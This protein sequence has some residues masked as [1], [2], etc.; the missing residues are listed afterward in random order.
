[1]H[2]PASDHPLASLPMDVLDRRF[3]IR[4]AGSTVGREVQAGVL[5]FATLSYILFVQ[6]AVLGG[7]GMDPGG[8]LF[9]TCVA[10]AIACLWMG[11]FANHPFALAPAMGHNFFFAFVVC[12]AM[13]FSWQ[14][15]LAANLMAG[16]VFLLLAPTRFRESVMQAVPAPVR[17]GIAAGIGLLV[18]MIGLQWSGLVVDSPATLVQLGD[19]ADPVAGL[20]LFGLGLGAVL[21]AARVPGA[22]LLS[23]VGTA[24][25]GVAAHELFGVDTALVQLDGVISAPP[26]PS[27]TAF[28]LDF[29]GLFARPIGDWLTVFAVLFLLD[30]FDTVGSLVGLGRRAGSL[31]DDG[32]LP[33]AS[34]AFTADAAGT[35][36]G[37]CLGTSTVTSY[38][39]SAAGI[40]AGGRTGLT[41]VVT[42]LL[43]LAALFFAPLFE[44]IGG[45][46]PVTLAGGETVVRYP[47]LAPVLIIVGALM[48]SALG[49][50]DWEDFTVALPAFLTAFVIPLTFSITDGI[51]A[52]FAAWTLLDIVR[53]GEVTTRTRLL[54]H[55]LTAVF[56]GRSV[57]LS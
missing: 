23:I 10:S 22:L 50:V 45:G 26:S 57:F 18:A 28:Q 3:G 30:L 19:L 51:A 4:A 1:M 46:V 36:A 38:V 47:V 31:R 9:A 24:G 25:A 39:E 41:A 32:S 12:G 44:A 40:A 20:S 27:E 55:G 21:F 8:V 37:A 33:R 49:D 52:G 14:Q 48:C 5:T 15:A 34:A 11:W 16:L 53:P 13:G 17:A 54:S 2:Q 7:V 6:P 35:V 43:F 42:G 29:A 56:V